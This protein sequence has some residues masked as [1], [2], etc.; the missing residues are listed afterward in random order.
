M[1]TT[2]VD[3]SM[4]P[5]SIRRIIPIAVNVFVP[6]AMPNRVL[7]SFGIALGQSRKPNDSRLSGSLPR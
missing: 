4:L 3:S 2:G 6:E 1:S 5:D 7:T